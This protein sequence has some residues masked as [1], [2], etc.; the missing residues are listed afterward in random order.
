[1]RTDESV[2]SADGTFKL[3]YHS[4][5]GADHEVMLVHERTEG[6]SSNCDPY[7]LVVVP[8]EESGSGHGLSDERVQPDYTGDDLRQLT[9]VLRAAMCGSS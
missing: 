6:A 3:E 9:G 8:L 7:N 1:M 2:L 5:T 4:D